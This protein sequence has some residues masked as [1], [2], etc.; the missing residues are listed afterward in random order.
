DT[1]NVDSLYE[2]I[3]DAVAD[4]FGHPN[5]NIWLIDEAAG[6]AILACT[7]GDLPDDM[8]RRLKIDGP[9]LIPL[10]VRTA[11]IVNVPD[12]LEDPRYLPGLVDTRAELLVPLIV[13][14]RVIAVF[15][16]ESPVQNAFTGRDER[17]LSSFAERAAR[18]V[19][20]ARFYT[21]AQESAPSES[22]VNPFTSFRNRTFT[23]NPFF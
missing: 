2:Q 1:F 17:I 9:G 20:Q 11:S 21:R 23:V 10:A 18:A 13:G 16:L 3:L 6:A 14:Q 15:N 12:V 5:S 8:L 7:R 22:L 4:V 19:E